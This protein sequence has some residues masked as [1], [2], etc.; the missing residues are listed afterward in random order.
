MLVASVPVLNPVKALATFDESVTSALA[1][2]PFNLVWSASVNTLESL[3]DSTNAL[4]SAAVWSP[5]APASIPSN[6][7]WSAVVK[8]SSV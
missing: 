2:I 8:F 3:A 7:A 4:I 6:L 5:V 1:S